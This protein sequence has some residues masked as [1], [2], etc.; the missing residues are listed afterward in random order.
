MAAPTSD[1][2]TSWRVR[3][4]WVACLGLLV[5]HAFALVGF[6]RGLPEPLWGDEQR[7]AWTVMASALELVWLPWR[8]ASHDAAWPAPAGRL[9]LPLVLGWLAAEGLMAVLAHRIRRSLL[10]RSG[11]HAVVFGRSPVGEALAREW[12][13]AGRPVLVVTPREEDRL[14]SQSL[15]A[16]HMLGEATDPGAMA[17]AALATADFV[18]CVHD[19]DLSNIDAALAVAE[20]ARQHRNGG[21]PLQQVYVHL[22]N[23]HVRDNLAQRLQG[24]H[25]LSELH[26]F[27][28]PQI[29]VRKLLRERPMNAC[30]VPGRTAPNLWVFG[31]GVLA[32]ELVLNFLRL[33][34]YLH[35]QAPSVAVIDRDAATFK[36]AFADHWGQSARVANVKFETVGA[37]LGETLYERLVSTTGLPNAVW[38][39]GPDDAANLAAA[40]QL[41]SAFEGAGRPTPPLYVRQLT[42]A[43]ADARTTLDVHP[44][45][46]PFGSASEAATELLY[47]EKL[48]GMARMTHERYVREA[49]ERGGRLGERRSLVH[50][51]EL[52]LD[53]K[54]DNRNVADHHFVK[55]VDTGC[56]LEPGGGGTFEWSPSE[57]EGLSR[58][59]HERWVVQRELAGWRLAPVRDD[60]RKLHPDLVPW[61]DLG[62]A[63]R[64]LDRDVVLQVPALF[65]AI[66]QGVHRELPVHVSG[67]RAPWAFTPSFE[68]AV[69]PLL[70]RIA[71]ASEATVPRI[72]LTN[73]SAMAWRVAELWLETSG[74]LGLEL[75]EPAARVLASQPTEAARSRVRSV[76]RGATRIV[77]T[78]GRERAERVG[79]R[80]L[81]SI[82]G[83]GLTPH[84]GDWGLDAEGRLLFEPQP[85]EASA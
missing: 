44:W 71:S 54:D 85:S 5:G 47:G 12:L 18:A 4:V 56:S 66:G 37:E 6:L 3:T 13:R 15:G 53:L 41:C 30:R 27:S 9:V 35:G 73:D 78:G 83:Q 19:A 51:A 60:S 48:D 72:W 7:H 74:L 8:E 39:T 68:A 45:L 22:G 84:P 59:E 24:N 80:L 32:E 63:R 58:A 70:R 62:D 61:K 49:L 10:L 76:L 38:F 14:P 31:A 16:S 69:V 77:F 23:V 64:Q 81:L 28:A 26:V 25:H 40:V 55:L 75:H 52:P 46:I 21:R 33:G 42:G 29:S 20:W 43:D 34:C 11:G 67:P 79:P 65:G 2:R 82:D 17:R 50:W 36:S 57:V 1:H